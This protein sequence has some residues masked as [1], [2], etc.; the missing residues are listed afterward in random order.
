VNATEAVSPEVIQLLEGCT[1]CRVWAEQDEGPYRRAAPPVRRDV[2]EGRN[3]SPLQLG[4]R[5]ISDEQSALRDG[6]VEIWHCDHLGRYSGFPPP[7]ESDVVTAATASR[8]AYLPD[9]TFLRGSQTTDATGAVEFRTI[10]PGWY[11]GRTIHIH[12]IVRTPNAVFTSQLYF[13]DQLNEEVLASEPYRDHP[14]RDTTNDT[15]S[16]FPTGG[17]PA[18]LDVFPND[19]GHRAAVCLV[20]ARQP[21]AID[22]DSKSTQ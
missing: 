9:E 10:Y 1:V 11:P 5:L 14:G 20:L 6:E 17:Q 16:I 12:T 18:V 19:R 22:A 8:V 2:I 21:V 3:G 4:I 15:D 13:P 7:D